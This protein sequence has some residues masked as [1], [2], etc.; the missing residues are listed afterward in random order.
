MIAGAGGIA[1][2]VVIFFCRRRS[3]FNVIQIGNRLSKSQ[4]CAVQNSESSEALPPRTSD[5]KPTA[6][7]S[8][9]HTEIV[10]EAE[11][12][13]PSSPAL[14]DRRS[15]TWSGEAAI[16]A[17]PTPISSEGRRSDDAAKE[18]LHVGDPPS[19]CDPRVTRRLHFAQPHA[20]DAAPLW[21]SPP[22]LSAL[23]RAQGARMRREDGASACGPDGQP[24]RGDVTP[25]PLPPP[26]ASILRRAQAEVSAGPSTTSEEGHQELRT[27]QIAVVRC[28]RA[29]Y[30]IPKK[31]L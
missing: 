11:E 31:R 5:S 9:S 8:L 20:G 16:S 25:A 14:P 28:D 12:A 18:P 22:N 26:D 2:C 10:L 13:A 23:R 29:P 6:C 17:G 30:R 21:H 3:S 24:Q 27:N 7:N 15:R 19:A 1:F 4:R